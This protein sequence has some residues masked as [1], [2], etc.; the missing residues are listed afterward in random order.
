MSFL[1]DIIDKQRLKKCLELL[2][3][4]VATSVNGQKPNKNGAVNIGIGVESVDGIT[5]D[6]AGNVKIPVASDE[7]V[8]AG[9]T[10]EKYM[11]PANTLFAINKRTANYYNSVET[12]KADRKLKAGMTACTLGYYSPN[13][14]GAGTYIIRA[15]A[16]GDVDDGGSLHE[17]TSGLVAELVVNDWVNTLQLGLDK[18]DTEGTNL[19]KLSIAI[20]KG[21]KIIVSDIYKI[22]QVIMRSITNNIFIKGAN[23]NCGFIVETNYNYIFQ[24]GNKTKIISI[25]GIVY[26]SQVKGFSRLLYD[27]ST[28]NNTTELERFSIQNCIIRNYATIIAENDA[29]D[30]L[31]NN[32]EKLPIYHNV[33]YCNNRFENVE[34]Y[35][36]RNGN[37]AYDNFIFENNTIHNFKG[38]IL[39]LG[40]TNSDNTSYQNSRYAELVKAKKHFAFRNNTIYCDDN[41]ILSDETDI[42]YY[43][44]ITLEGETVIFE[45]NT[46]EGL[47]ASVNCA[48]YDSYLSCTN[49]YYYNNV[50]RNNICFFANKTYN[51]IMKAKFG[52]GV[53]VYK[54]NIFETTQDYI[55]MLNSS[56]AS[57]VAKTDFYQMCRI[58]MAETIDYNTWIIRDNVFNLFVF[59]V[60]HDLYA[61]KEYTF[62]NNEIN[63]TYH[64]GGALLY[65]GSSKA[66]S[67]VLRNNT[68][69]LGTKLGAEPLELFHTTISSIKSNILF[70]NN[71]IT[72][73]SGIDVHS[74][75][76][77]AKAVLKNNYYECPSIANFRL[78]EIGSVVNSPSISKCLMY[79]ANC[80]YLIKGQNIDTAVFLVNI[81]FNE[82][83]DCLLTLDLEC[84]SNDV[85][86]KPTRFYFK[87]Y[88]TNGVRKIKWV[89]SN[90]V[91]KE[92]DF[93]T[94]GVVNNIL[95]SKPEIR[96]RTASDSV[97]S[98]IISRI[99]GDINLKMN[100]LDY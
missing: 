35:N 31:Y 68:I 88:E 19:N 73:L 48:L 26:D 52:N 65:I 40:I 7:E 100:Y 49:V 80:E 23:K 30:R 22:K 75:A 76:V 24:F 67:Y 99:D 66:R 12:M 59:S 92:S 63:A 15:K 25:D 98:L 51:A 34:F 2:K 89:D 74:T 82:N 39:S 16:D 81:S 56:F 42:E 43:S 60:A 11:T 72:S 55:D 41:Y 91:E 85:Y 18:N 78:S 53:R 8:A 79:I 32:A 9:E 93:K 38:V 17:L 50:V 58:S 87:V 14:G 94:S 71:K 70:E 90:G 64:I 4:H 13:D 37:T 3:S 1:K 29:S 10:N 96:L 27:V 5:P 84:L 28:S 33:V 46:I 95:Y 86:V 69:I 57:N 83:T 45:N 6:E 47:K 44:P 62:E 77:Q 36:I 21:F 20:N 61:V 97:P 54:N